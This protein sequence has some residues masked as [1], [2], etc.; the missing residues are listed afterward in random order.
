MDRRIV[1]AA[2]MRGWNDGEAESA[3]H[4]D[5]VLGLPTI[6]VAAYSGKPV[7]QSCARPVGQHALDR[8]DRFATCPY[9]GLLFGSLPDISPR[10]ERPKNKPRR[11]RS[12]LRHK[13]RS[14]RRPQRAARV[15]HRPARLSA[16]AGRQ[17]LVDLHH[18][19]VLRTLPRLLAPAGQRDLVGQHLPAAVPPRRQ[20]LVDLH[21]LSVLRAPPRLL[22]PAGQRDLVGQ[23]LPAA[24]AGRQVLVAPVLPPRPVVQ[25]VPAFV[26][27][28][29]AP[30]S[31]ARVLKPQLSS[32]SPSSSPA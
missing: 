30:S 19:S 10:R 16:P 20:V 11:P 12:H 27:S 14:S 31:I 15:R 2:T 7:R 25:P 5:A 4:V 13:Q 6:R 8:A 26:R 21:H 17:V 1:F 22:A 24:P 32:A 9:T 28:Q 18:L 29:P 3:L 23:H